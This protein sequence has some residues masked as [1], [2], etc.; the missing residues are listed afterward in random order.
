MNLV[1]YIRS[2]LSRMQVQ[3]TDKEKIIFVAANIA[4]AIA[5]TL[6]I[7]S[8]PVGLLH[9]HFANSFD[10]QICDIINEF[11][12]QMIIDTRMCRDQV[13]KFYKLRYEIV[14]SPL[15]FSHVLLPI[16]AALPEY[17][18]QDVCDLFAKTIEMSDSDRVLYFSD[19]DRATRTVIDHIREKEQS[20]TLA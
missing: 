3:L 2:L 12:E 1:S 19:W 9:T 14:H 10:K 13:F 15:V 7:P 5:D 4:R 16:S 8:S 11:N 18:A 6:P 17:F 20:V